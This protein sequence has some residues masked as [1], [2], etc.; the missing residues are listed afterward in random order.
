MAV[1]INEME[2]TVESRGAHADAQAQ[3]AQSSGAEMSDEDFR[4]RYG[5]VLRVMIRDELERYLRTAGD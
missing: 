1:V 5:A 4:A 3:A 2:S